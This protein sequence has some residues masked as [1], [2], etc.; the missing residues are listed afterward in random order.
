MR[1][2]QTGNVD[3]CSLFKFLIARFIAYWEN[4]SNPTQ[5]SRP[6]P[7]APK[8]GFGFWI[9]RRGRYDYYRTQNSEHFVWVYWIVL[10]D[11]SV[12]DRIWNTFYIWYHTSLNKQS[13]WM[14]ILGC[15]LWEVRRGL[16]GNEAINKQFRSIFVQFFIISD[17]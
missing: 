12:S 14:F 8:M 1:R 15:A 13:L 5:L 2:A 7:W 3:Y 16:A 17:Q 6:P 9:N 10:R 11:I 4:S